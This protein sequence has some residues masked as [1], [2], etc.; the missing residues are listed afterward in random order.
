MKWYIA[1]SLYYPYKETNMAHAS[2]N[3]DIANVPRPSGARYII[4][5]NH[6]EIVNTDGMCWYCGRIGCYL[7]HSIDD[8]RLALYPER[9]PYT[10]CPECHTGH[11]LRMC[12]QAQATQCPYCWSFHQYYKFCDQKKKELDENSCQST[13]GGAASH[14]VEAGT[15][16]VTSDS[17]L[18]D[19]EFPTL[20]GMDDPRQCFTYP[21][22]L[23]ES[24]LA[25]PV[26]QTAT[27]F[28]IREPALILNRDT[29]YIV[30]LKNFVNC[31]QVGALWRELGVSELRSAMTVSKFP[32]HDTVFVPIPRPLR[33]EDFEYAIGHW[34][35]YKNINSDGDEYIRHVRISPHKIKSYFSEV[36]TVNENE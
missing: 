6:S 15:E 33:S 21:V 20:Q 3:N 17:D 4:M 34:Y 7:T 36:P 11:H 1:F 28:T 13:E 18:V 30:R 14:S 25:C 16:D 8:M 22:S 9:S 2:N 23:F 32:K 5:N 31:K 24:S 27:T 10:E 12:T 29:K 26:S 35:Y 19:D